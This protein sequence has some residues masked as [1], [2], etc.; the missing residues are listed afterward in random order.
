MVSNRTDSF[1]IISYFLEEVMRNM[2]MTLL[3]LL[4]FIPLISMPLFAEVFDTNSKLPDDQPIWKNPKLE[5]GPNTLRLEASFIEKKIISSYNQ[6]NYRKDIYLLSYDIK[7]LNERYPY[8]TITFIV[9]D[10]MPAKG[11]KIN[12]KK[13]KNPFEEGVTTF[14]LEPDEGVEFRKFYNIVK[15]ES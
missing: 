8:E 6:G 9:K 11:S 5:M 10:F 12:F 2:K 7:N 4:L 1:S 3:R 13:L 15:H 14:Y